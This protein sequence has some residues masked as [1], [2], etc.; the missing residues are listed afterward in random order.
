MKHTRRAPRSRW[1]YVLVLCAVTGGTVSCAATPRPRVLGQADA[2]AESPAAREAAQL[3]PQAFAHAENLRAAA[4]AAHQRSEFAAAQI[5][6]EHSLA[7]YDHAFV[8]AR[9][10]KAEQ[11]L[12]RA[13]AALAKTQTELAELDE[14]QLRLAAEADA[15]ELKIKVTVDKEPK[16]K[17]PPASPERVR[18]RRD[19]ARALTSEARL[20]CLATE[21]LEPDRE[22]LGAA[23][24]TVTELEEELA[25]G[26]HK[27]ELFLRATEARTTCLRQLTLARR[28]ATTKAPEAGVTDR[29]FLEL[30]ETQRFFAFRDDRGIVINLRDLTAADGTL[31]A[32]AR[33]QLRLLGGTAKEHSGFP[34]LVV[35]HAAQPKQ[36]DAAKAQAEL[37]AAALREAGA[38]SVRVH[39]AGTAQPVVDGRVPDAAARNARIEVVFVSPAR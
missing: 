22:G 21:L 27:D 36:E 18:A 31:T 28:P 34:L 37:V 23:R 16:G 13:E 24:T 26:S 2:A 1:W 19:A 25:K 20:L 5:L 32:D 10:V 14:Q 12:A 33:E 4:A 3:A 8:L 7:A 6:G 17:L 29:L 38:P 35:G 9:Y 30:T 11:R 39:G 15:L